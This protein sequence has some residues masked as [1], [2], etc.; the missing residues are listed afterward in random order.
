MK[1]SAFVS[2]TA[3]SP[4][5]CE[6]D[7]VIK[8]IIEGQWKGRIDDIRTLDKKAYDDAKRSLPAITW[9][10]QFKER[11]AAAIESYSGYI[12]LD[13]DHIEPSD[14]LNLKVKLREESCVY[15]AFAS[16]SGKGLKILCHVNTDKD[17]HLSAFLHLQHYFENK[18]LL[19]IDDSGK[20]I[21]RLC[22][23]S[24]DPEALHKDH[25]P[26]IVD[27]K[28]GVV[29]NYNMPAG[30]SN[31][32]PQKD[33]TKLF[34]LCV[35][36]V[37][38]TCAYVPGMRN[39]YCHAISCA[40]NRLGAS[41]QDTENILLQNYDLDPKEIAH[42]V[43][44][45]YFHYSHE[46]GSVEAKDTS[47][48]SNF[49]APPYIQNFTDDVVLNDLMRI[50]ANLYHYKLAKADI[51]DIVAKIAKYYKKEGLI[52]LDRKSLA[53]LINDAIKILNSKVI[54][55]T[56]GLTLKYTTAEEIGNEIINIDVDGKSI[57]TTFPD[58]DAATRGGLMPGNFY[59]MVGV[60][61][62]YKSIV[63]QY[64][65]VATAYKDKAVLY[66]NGEMSQF[67]FYE[68]LCS[69]TMH[70][71]LYKEMSDKRLTKENV[72]DLIAEMNTILKHN[73]FF[74]GGTGFGKDAILATIANIEAKTGKTIAMV[75]VDGV[76]QMDSMNMQ[77][78]P[79]CI[80]NTRLCKE[81]AKNAH[82]GEGVV[83][84]GLMHVS[85]E[86]ESAKTRRDNSLF[87]RG[88]GKTIANADGYFS[89]SLLVDP[90]TNDL[91]STGDVLYLEDKFYLRFHDK[92]NNG[93]TINQIVNVGPNI[94]LETEN[95]D[96]RSYEVKI[97]PKR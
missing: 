42:V 22:F 80:E 36:W 35:K 61:G 65:A 9:S 79:A 31:Y 91:D 70:M 68:R 39:K 71:N 26:F 38:N 81:I 1:I 57:A 16:P 3:T 41:A 45:S 48:V 92:R 43:K 78:I 73:L 72:G 88:G 6:L 82:D 19:K 83:V 77:E 47:S 93:G 13:I 85:G 17:Q 58:I 20:D 50:S 21:C 11:K 87:C 90:T 69:M 59:I 55:A 18:Y 44:S 67:Q 51:W 86:Q 76:S 29:N 10:G 28:F 4:T 24:H 15:F 96:P 34:E 60:G 5:N 89:T 54:E 56:D 30:L 25:S 7:S 14:V 84:V 97:T 95:V 64:M 66:L 75:I 23:V 32:K 94:T 12:I 53:T 46:H 37:G 2:A 40:M 62:T 52:D 63:A 8:G 49:K 33:V 74:V 27:L